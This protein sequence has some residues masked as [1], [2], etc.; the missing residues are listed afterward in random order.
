MSE[1]TVRTPRI[2][3]IHRRY[4]GDLILLEPFLR[5][6]RSAHPDAWLVLVADPGYA[7]VLRGCDSIDAIAELPRGFDFGAWRRFLAEIATEP[8][9]LAFDLTRNERSALALV[10]SR[11]RRRVSYDVEGDIAVRRRRSMDAWRRRLVTTDVLRVTRTEQKSMHI[12]DWHNRLLERVGIPAPHTVPGLSIDMKDRRRASALLERELG[13]T[14]GRRVLVHVGARK[15]AKRWPTARFA[16]L[17]DG[18]DEELGCLPVLVA[19]PGEERVL[20]SVVQ[21][22][23]RSGGAVLETAPD[24]ALLY[25]LAAECD[26]YVGNDSAP[27]HMAAAVGTPACVLFCDASPVVWRTR[28][29][30]DRCLQAPLPCGDACV[31]PGVCAP[32]ADRYCVRRIGVEEVMRAVGAMLA[33]KRA[34]PVAANRTD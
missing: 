12:V 4:A 24:L 13:A 25:G 29:S 17:A 31:R 23:A 21:A 2:L 30:R 14:P 34:S 11:S 9:D 6:L 33:E 20:R 19:G 3:V 22:R 1:G 8:F 27:A 5:N 15:E 28:G 26:L 32:G 10:L 7:D 16:A 18:L